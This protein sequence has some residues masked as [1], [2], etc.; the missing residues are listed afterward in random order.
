MLFS[1]DRKGRSGH[2]G[3]HVDIRGNALGCAVGGR[4]LVRPATRDCMFPRASAALLGNVPGRR[5]PDSEAF[6][7]DTCECRSDTNGTS[8]SHSALFT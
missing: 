5:I 3:T 6:A 8:L 2:R 7:A 4:F 1:K